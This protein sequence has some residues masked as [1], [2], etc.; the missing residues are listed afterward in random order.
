MR[1][2]EHAA[3]WIPADTSCHL[4]DLGHQ[5]KRGWKGAHGSKPQQVCPMRRRA[6]RNWRQETNETL[7]R[8]S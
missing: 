5:D 6:C 8:Q 7:T 3:T 4:H 2:E 1:T